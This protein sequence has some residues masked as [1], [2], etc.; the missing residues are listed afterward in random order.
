MHHI[1]STRFGVGS[2]FNR[3]LVPE[4]MFANR[5]GRQPEIGMETDRHRRAD[6]WTW[7]F[8]SSSVLGPIVDNH[9]GKKTNVKPKRDYM[10]KSRQVLNGF[11]GSERFAL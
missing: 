1:T 8:Q 6:T 9:A 2:H 4:Q 7:T 10:G 5:L 3:L 11:H